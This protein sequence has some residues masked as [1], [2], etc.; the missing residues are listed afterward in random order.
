M[1]FISVSQK[2]II[3]DSISVVEFYL[4]FLLRKNMDYNTWIVQ[5]SQ[6]LLKKDLKI[7]DNR[8]LMKKLNKLVD[9]KKMKI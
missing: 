7:T 6:H 2:L 4:Y 9:V 5:T 3:D 1:N 8:T